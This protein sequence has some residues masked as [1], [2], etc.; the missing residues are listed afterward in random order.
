MQSRGEKSA[1]INRI[2]RKLARHWKKL[3]ESK[4]GQGGG[5]L[6]FC[7]R[8]RNTKPRR[9]IAYDF[10]TTPI[11]EGTPTALYLTA[12]TEG[13]CASTPI[14]SEQHLADLL[15]LR[16]LTPEFN[17]ARFVAWNGNGFDVYFVARAL[18]KSERYEIRP[19]LTR[20]KNVRGLKVTL[21]PAYVRE[22]VGHLPAKRQPKTL[23]WEFLDGM[24]MTVGNAP[25]RLAEFI[26]KMA[27]DFPKLTEIGPD[28]EGGERF[29]PK[30]PDHVKYAER[31][32]EGLYHAMMRAQGIV[33][34]NFGLALQPTVGNLAI[35]IFQANMPLGVN[36]WEPTFKVA[37]IIRS[38][39]MRGG[40]CHHARQWDG[41]IWKYDLN[42]AYAAAMRD[43]KL[44]GGRCAHLRKYSKYFSAAIYRI[45]ARHPRR[46]LV[47]FYFIDSEGHAQFNDQ[48]IS[49]TWITSI[50]W[51]QLRAEG[52]LIDTLEGFGWEETF[53]MKDYVSKLEALRVTAPDGP[54]GALGTMVKS[55]GNNSYGK[56]VEMLDGM[57]LLMSLEK[58]EDFHSYQ[59]DDEQLENVW[60][61]FRE[62]QWREYHQPQLG[63]FITAHVRMLVRRAALL[64]PREWLY[65]D[66]DCVV[67]S[68][69]V[70]LPIDKLKYGYWKIEEEGE[71]YWMIAKKVYAK[72]AGDWGRKHARHAKG[73]NVR[74]LDRNHFKR[75]YE[76]LPPSQVQAQRVNFVQFV[77]GAE[78]FKNREKVG[79]RLS[80]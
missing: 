16:F 54:S 58:P 1:R 3:R 21:K 7:R 9:L 65:A 75:W 35:K 4:G 18:L 10:E 44:P 62:P 45:K 56:T 77:A 31:D 46:T 32:S 2:A 76:G 52:W 69:P 42:Q 50:E 71:P 37:E 78:M 15:Q 22:L 59:A 23:S 38:R 48:E 8:E 63:A 26:D 53:S 33:M 27:P 29:D 13:W 68:R 11:Q 36:C 5:K 80:A 41:P 66:T 17:R 55:I 6:P 49:D 64:A 79:Q 14:Q 60:F 12:F 57:E 34:E 25:M 19:F 43:A 30:N 70:K 47:P 40:Y 51:E 20:S 28:F 74:R 61:K 72:Q 67:F 24:A 73:M 39:V